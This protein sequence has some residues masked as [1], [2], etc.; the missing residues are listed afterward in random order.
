MA[1]F[2]YQVAALGSLNAVS[3]T[4]VP[5]RN[6]GFNVSINDTFVGTVALQHSFPNDF[7]TVAS[8]TVVQPGTVYIPGQ[9]ITLASQAA[10]TPPVVTIA[11]TQVVSATVNAAGSG[12]TNGTQTVTGTTG[13]G[14]K[15]TASV[16]VAGGAITAVLSITLRGSYSVNPTSLAAE[17]VTGGSVTGATLAV[18]MGVSTV[19]ISTAGNAFFA[20]TNGVTQ[21][22]TSGSGTGATFNI[23]TNVLWRTVTIW[24]APT[25]SQA[26]EVENGAIYRLSMTVYTS[27]TA[28]VRL[29]QSY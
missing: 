16:T 2:P 15:F 5:T 6:R 26:T 11:T 7:V 23:T 1:D 25:E 14:T 13:T 8:A 10:S 20:S 12:G 9:T 19:T 3:P 29:G 18:V 22:A 4:F 21:S 27:G 28:A 24:T 17:P